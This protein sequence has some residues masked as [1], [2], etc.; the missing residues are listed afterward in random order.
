MTLT[1]AKPAGFSPGTRL[2]AS[3]LNTIQ[4]EY[5]KAVDGYGGGTYS[6]TAPLVLSGN[7]LIDSTSS[8][9]CIDLYT[10]NLNVV[11]TVNTYEAIVGTDLD[12][13]GEITLPSVSKNVDVVMTMPC[14]FLGTG[15]VPSQWVYTSTTGTPYGIKWIQGDVGLGPDDQRIAFTLPL[16]RGGSITNI[17]MYLSGNGG[18]GGPHSALPANLPRIR[19]LKLDSTTR[20]VSVLSTT[21]DAPASPGA[22]DTLHWLTSTSFT[23]VYDPSNQYL[24]EIRGENGTNALDNA[25]A[26]YALRVSYTNDTIE[27]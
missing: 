26:V 4:D 24:I 20:A 14:L 16:L 22:Y 15:L 25:L 6:L 7:I 17:A 2:L 5:I 19:L 8:V 11:G 10:D 23:E 18:G 12:V 13:G 27:L 3:E 1:R 9:S 21:T